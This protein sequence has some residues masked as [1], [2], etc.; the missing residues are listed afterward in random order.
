MRKG[1]HEEEGFALPTAVAVTFIIFL[2]LS[3]T[4]AHTVRSQYSTRIQWEVYAA[5]TAAESGIAK[6]QARLRDQ[7]QWQGKEELRWN[8]VDVTITVFQNGNGQITIVSIG[9]AKQGVKQTIRVVL[10]SEKYTII[11]WEG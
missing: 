11:E 7:P 3:A 4:I 8:D 9:R 1:W 2:L 5:Q 10:E 6:M